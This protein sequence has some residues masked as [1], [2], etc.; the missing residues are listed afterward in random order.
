VP[1]FQWSSTRM[2]TSQQRA[3]LVDYGRGHCADARARFQAGAG[4][5]AGA[6]FTNP[7]IICICASSCGKVVNG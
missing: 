7:Y 6:L 1:C 2:T 3:E 4:A 5:G